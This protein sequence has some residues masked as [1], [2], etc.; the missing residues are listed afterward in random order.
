MA[1][2]GVNRRTDAQTPDGRITQTRH[3]R[4]HVVRDGSHPQLTDNPPLCLRLET[5]EAPR[6][7]HPV[8]PQEIDHLVGSV[9][10]RP[11]TGAVRSNEILL[12]GLTSSCLESR[13]IKAS[14]SSSSTS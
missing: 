12:I 1:R 10:R 2:S 4:D 8:E 11:A 14:S 9:A 5:V 6:V 13:G 3:R 7:V